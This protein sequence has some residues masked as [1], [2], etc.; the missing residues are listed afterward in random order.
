MFGYQWH[1][2]EFICV[3]YYY[4]FSFNFKICRQTH[5]ENLPVSGALHK[6]SDTQFF[7]CEVSD[8]NSSLLTCI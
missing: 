5:Y 4:T 7:L 8:W 2:E 3:M 1:D 6:I